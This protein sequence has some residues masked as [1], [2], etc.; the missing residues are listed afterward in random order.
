[1]MQPIRFFVPGLPQPGGSKRGFVHRHTG[2]VIVTEDCRRSKDWRAVVALE[3]SR[4]C[5]QPLTGPL[6]VRVVFQLPRPKGHYRTGRNAGMLRDSAPT[7]PITKPDATKL[8]R[9][10]ED[11]LKAIAWADDSQVVHQD[12]RKVYGQP[13]A[14]IEIREA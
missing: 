3:A 4:H 14:E 1:M 2:R 12:V 10:T 5:S 13:G 9:S 8:W 11:A 6:A 7:Y